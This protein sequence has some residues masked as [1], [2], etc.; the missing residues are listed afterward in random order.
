ML[1][2]AS[3]ATS[4]PIVR[5]NNSNQFTELNTPKYLHY[6]D[7]TEEFHN[8]TKLSPI[9][10]HLDKL[11]KI[12]EIAETEC[13]LTLTENKTPVLSMLLKRK[14]EKVEKL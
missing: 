1:G 9:H 11:A 6:A 8:I 12:L 14:K 7:L 13:Q 3:T 4:T 10:L 5:E 2:V